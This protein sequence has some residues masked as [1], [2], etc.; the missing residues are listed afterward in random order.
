MITFERYWPLLFIAAIPFVF[1]VRSRTLTDFNSSQ[2]RLATL[3]RSSMVLLLALALM[4]PIVSSQGSW[5]SVVY[6]LDVSES[7]SPQAIASAIDWIDAANTA[8]RPDHTSYIGFGANAIVHDDLDALRTIQVSDR[9]VDGAVDQSGTN[10]E[11]ALQRALGSFAPNHIKRLV[12]LSDGNQ[13]S[14]MVED[15]VLRLAEE[16]VQVF[17]RP[18]QARLSSDTW[19]EDLLAPARVT[20]EELFP[21]EVHVFSHSPTSASLDLRMGDE[22][23]ETRDI[24]LVEGINRIAFEVRV[25][26]TGPTT[27]EAEVRA[28]S[29]SFTGNNLFRESIVVGGSPRILYVEG[30]PESAG[31]LTDALELEGMEVVLATPSELPRVVEG[32]DGYESVILSDIRADEMDPAQMEALATY[33]EDLGGG[34]IL[35]GGESVFGE[36]GYSTT[37]V[38]EILPVSF[39]LEREEAS[40]ALIIVLDKSGSMGGQKIELAKE[41]SKAA[42][43]VLLDEHLIGIIAF[44][45]NHYWPVD[46]QL[47]ANRDDINRSVSMIIAGGETN[48]YPALREAN[49]ALLGVESEVKH[50][51]LLSDGR[52]LPDDYQGL[53]DEMAEAEM[54][55]STVAV[56]NGADRELLEDIAEWGKG[57]AYFI[58]DATMVPQIFTEETELA[59]QG[60]LEEEPFQVVVTK[61]AEVLDGI[62]FL[63][64]PL[65]LGYVS[66]LA[67]DTAEVLLESDTEKPILARWQYGLGKTAAFT[68]DVKDRWAVDWLAW[69]G[70]VKLW[71]QLVR[72]T[73]RRQDDEDLD[74]RIDKVGDE[75]R[76]TITALDPDG[77]FRNE[78]D[79]QIRVVDPDQSAAVI[80]VRQSGPGTYEARYP[81]DQDGSFVFRL[82]GD[83]AG[84]SRI[85]PYSYPEEYH[86]YPTDV[87]LL[88]EVSESTGGAFGAEAPTIFATDSETVTAP[89]PIWP[90]LTALAL[91]LYLT[92]LYLRRVRLFESRTGPTPARQASAPARRGSL[93]IS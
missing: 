15:T 80:E 31:Y 71:P 93:G 36:E 76:I 72:E 68:S 82:I 59:T 52:S 33:V 4:Q 67:K 19:V 41:A 44:D 79:S 35:A 9:S 57:R 12:L 55:V 63:D 60:T 73:M 38:E 17:A 10:L 85:L 8:G 16:G 48:I 53:V 64:S 92:E 23:L 39:D 13:N 50:V 42:V 25:E 61:D 26:E 24:A 49:A 18:I 46:L 86:F 70:Y 11:N 37:R 83:E 32:L 3:V 6:V 81:V 91:L 88:R 51:I 43:E 69:E 27:L 34:L 75:A 21:V 1:W 78:L 45:Y 77:G 29:D 66:T 5:L 65:L 22:V 2:L 90:Y 40:V 84:V 62:D 30:R 20:A 7:V 89:T 28:G 54:T 14:G 87:D 58:E 47:A 74:M 56:G